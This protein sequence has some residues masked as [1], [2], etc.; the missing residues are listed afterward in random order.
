MEQRFIQHR[1]SAIDW[2]NSERDFEKG[3]SLLQRSG[4]KPSVVAKLTRHGATG[5]DARGRLKHLVREL[6]AAWA[7]PSDALVP[8]TDGE[9]GVID[10]V[11]IETETVTSDRHCET[12]AA[13]A[14]KLE[15]VA[16]DYG[17]PH[18]VAEVIRHFAG[19]YKLRDR[20]HSRL[21][22]MPEDNEED[23]MAERK[24]IIEEIEKMSNLMD[25]LY[26]LYNHYT[27]TGE[28]V[29]PELFETAIRDVVQNRIGLE[30]SMTGKENY[31]PD[32]ESLQTMRKSI[33]TKI[34][35]AR[36]MLEF[37]QETK[38]EHPNPMPE[39]PKRVKYETK[40]ANLTAE[41]EKLDYQRAALV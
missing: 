40:V 31:F 27:L 9:L 34:L 25:R 12:L 18:T 29:A 37:Q 36:N 19:A 39:C 35:R 6:I 4:F 33:A 15:N 17:Y 14:E 1:Q 8:D 24:K 41:L 11:D 2:L 28:D 32:K 13:A 38:A 23:T 3:I 5:P 22:E 21:A 26:P 10:G 20:L 30:T 7:L 16:D